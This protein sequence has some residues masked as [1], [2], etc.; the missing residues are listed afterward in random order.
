MVWWLRLRAPNAGSLEF[1]PGQGTRSCML[2]L[3]I[4]T[5]SNKFL[6]NFK[7]VINEL[8]KLSEPELPVYKMGTHN[9]VPISLYSCGN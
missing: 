6:K 9:I 5:Q 7:Y 1:I 3:K 4:L 8:L 2:Q